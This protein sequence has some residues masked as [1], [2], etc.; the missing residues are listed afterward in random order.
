M[1]RHDMTPSACG[2]M[3]PAWR[4]KPASRPTTKKSIGS[5]RQVLCVS[6]AAHVPLL[7]KPRAARVLLLRRSRAADA[8]VPLTCRSADRATLVLRWQRPWDDEMK[9]YPN[10]TPER[11]E[12]FPVNA[13]R[14]PPNIRVHQA[15]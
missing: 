12:V 5:V 4:E 8:N 10:G 6:E 9:S 2:D 1:G 13:L 3:R 15:T 7:H 14:P 11:S